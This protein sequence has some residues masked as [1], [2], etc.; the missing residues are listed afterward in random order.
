M[1]TIAALPGDV[2][3]VEIPG[4][5]SVSIEPVFVQALTEGR[6]YK[7]NIW[8]VDGPMLLFSGGVEIRNSIA[9]S[10]ADFATTFLN[11]FGQSGGPSQ[12]V[13]LTAAEYAALTPP[14][15]DTIYMISEG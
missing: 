7:Y 1:L 5:G 9:P 10:G 11:N 13:V 12:V 6:V 14:D 15:D 8:Q 2:P 3:L 4:V